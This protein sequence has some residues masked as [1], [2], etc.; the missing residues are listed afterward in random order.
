MKPLST[1]RC[2]GESRGFALGPEVF[3][4]MEQNM[5]YIAADGG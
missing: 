4:E 5:N 2:P 3:L 1:P